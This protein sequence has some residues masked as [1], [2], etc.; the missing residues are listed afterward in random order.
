MVQELSSTYN[1]GYP[2]KAGDSKVALE[3]KLKDTRLS[4]TNEL[5]VKQDGSALWEGKSEALEVRIYMRS[6]KISAES[7]QYQGTSTPYIHR[8]L[9]SSTKC[10]AKDKV[11]S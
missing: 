3:G 10:S 2:D 7:N 8:G 11:G 4:M 9:C 5:V 6:L 1:L